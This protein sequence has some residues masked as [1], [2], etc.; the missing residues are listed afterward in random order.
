MRRFTKCCSRKTLHYGKR[1]SQRNIQNPSLPL[2]Y[3]TKQ[4]RFRNCREWSSW[5]GKMKFQIPGRRCLETYTPHTHAESHESHNSRNSPSAPVKSQIL[6]F[7][8][9]KGGNHLKV[10]RIYIPLRITCRYSCLNMRH[11]MGCFMR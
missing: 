2:R 11:R 6:T 3:I 8:S 1:K 4:K 9:S 10:L 5:L 7:A